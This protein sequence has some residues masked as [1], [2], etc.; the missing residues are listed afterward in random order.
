MLPRR[1]ERIQN[2][3]PRPLR[4]QDRLHLPAHGRAFQGYRG[5]RARREGAVAAGTAGT[6]GGT[7]MPDLPPDLANHPKFRNVRELVRG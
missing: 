7:L 2:L 4:R 3:A 1:R 6:T 5:E